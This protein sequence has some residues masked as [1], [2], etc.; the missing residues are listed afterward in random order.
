MSPLSAPSFL[1][2]VLGRGRRH[3][4][5]RLHS[6]RHFVAAFLMKARL[7]TKILRI[8]VFGVFFPTVAANVLVTIWKGLRKL[9][10]RYQPLK[11]TSSDFNFF[12]IFFPKS[13]SNLLL[14]TR[15]QQY[16]FQNCWD[17]ISFNLTASEFKDYIWDN[18]NVIFN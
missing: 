11:C 12:F 6:A 4:V 1:S 2:F 18:H 14:V 5:I 16:Q 13:F 8:C 15:L 9:H 7:V 10:C 3:F 17:Y